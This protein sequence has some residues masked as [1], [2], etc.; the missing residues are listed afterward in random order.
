MRWIITCIV[1]ASVFWGPQDAEAYSGFLKEQNSGYVKLAF[2]TI[3]SNDFYDT[4]GNLFDFGSNFTQHTLSLY[5]E[6]GLLPYLTAGVSA[7]V[8]RLNSFATSDTAAGVGD[9]QLFLKTGLEFAGFHGAFMVAAELPTGRREALVDTE[10]EGVRSNLPTGDGETNF[11]LR[12]ALSRSL[13]T[14]DSLPAYASV[15]VGYNVR[16]KFAEQVDTGFE[17]G[18]QLFGW[19]WLQGSLSAQFTPA[20]VE[21]LDPTGI[22]LF[23]E[24]TEY[25]AGGLSASAR[26]PKTPL[27]L[28]F[29]FRNTF[30]NRRNL[31]AGST[32][33]LGLAADW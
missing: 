33:G 18:V 8:L 22:F 9:L 29:D 24:G 16:T 7:P 28:S 1:V 2:N 12:L 10:F 23:G 31:Y 17:L 26:I 5:G 6:F 30:A 3:S 15:Y 21:D 13:P 25:V 11:W 20:A 4:S 27:W 19:V 32:F 14:P